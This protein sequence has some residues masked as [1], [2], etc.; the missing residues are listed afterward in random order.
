MLEG[1]G[2]VTPQEIME[3]DRQ[4]HL[5]WANDGSRA[6]AGGLARMSTLDATPGQQNAQLA[7]PKSAHEKTLAAKIGGVLNT[8]LWAPKES[9]EASTA[10]PVRFVKARYIGGHSELGPPCS[11]WLW[12]TTQFVGIEVNPGDPITSLT[13]GKRVTASVPMPMVSRRRR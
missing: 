12:V 13:P 9:G 10:K 2:P 1:H 5:V 7:R 11:G 4:R 8:P 3:Y 6:W